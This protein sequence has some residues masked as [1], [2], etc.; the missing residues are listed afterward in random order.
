MLESLTEPRENPPMLKANF[1]SAFLITLISTL[2]TLFWLVGCSSPEEKRA[3]QLTEAQ[4]LVE[5]GQMDEALELLEALAVEYPNDLEIL[6]SMGRIYSRQGDE[7]LAA[8][9]LEQAHLQNPDDT[10]LL[11]DTYRSLEAAGQPAGA[12]LE[13]LASQAPQAMTP[14]LWVR[15]GQ[16]RPSENTVQAALDAYLKGVDPDKATPPP[17]TAAAIGQLFV[18]AGNLAQAES[19]L[20]IAS[21]S[22]D[23]NA[24]TAL[25]GLLEINLRQKDWPEA[26][27]IVERLDKQFPGAL[28][29]SEWQQARKELE[30]WREAQ[31]AM[32]AKLAAA[33]AESESEGKSEVSSEGDSGTTDADNTVTEASGESKTDAVADLEAMEAMADQPAVEAEEGGDTIRFN[34][35]IAIEPADPGI[36]FEV[37]FDEAPIA[38]ETTYSV[39]TIE[40]VE[41]QPLAEAASL[42]EPESFPFFGPAT[43]ATPERASPATIEE[44]LADAETAELDRDFKSA[45]RKYWAA[46]S[47]RNDRADVWNL[48]SRAYL[49]DGQIN[50]AETAALEAVRLRPSQVAYTLDYLRV[51]QR[52]KA[53]LEFVSEL[54]TAY[55]RFPASPEIT[56][57]LARAHER[58]TEEAATARTLYQ[59][60]IDIAPNHPLIPEAQNAVTR[61]Q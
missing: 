17:A 22:N 19:W 23:P 46:I 3:A 51:A 39:E 2:P 20:G 48:L 26:E 33:E 4:S 55:A 61:L 54:E 24:L 21:E 40:P 56:L 29:A 11:F 15:L 6:T 57:S 59:K 30:R 44:L 13:K 8:F 31:E 36:T 37:N 34:P 7:T 10:E 50:N 45:I 49:V 14:E 18:K 32:K 53:P 9:F 41:P 16:K 12:Y 28:E 60:F 43:P 42:P 35:D 47:I 27:A 1:K 25:F 52:T 58:I 38:G 5:A